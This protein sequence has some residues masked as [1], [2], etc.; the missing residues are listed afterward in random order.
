MEARDLY[1]IA[2]LIIGSSAIAANLT[3]IVTFCRFKRRILR[4]KVNKFLLSLAFADLL[5]GVFSVSLASCLLSN[6]HG[7]VYKVAGNIPLFGSFFASIL[8]LSLLSFDR[9][10]A[11][12]MPLRYC[13]IVTCRR[14]AVALASNWGFTFLM[15]VQQ[16]SFYF[17]FSYRV[18][19]RARGTIMIICFFVGATILTLTNVLLYK[20]TK[21]QYL[22]TTESEGFFHIEKSCGEDTG[23]GDT[24]KRRR[25]KMSDLAA[26]RECLC[27]VLVFICCYLPLSFYRLIYTYG[28]TFND[29]HGRRI[30]LLIALLSSVI[31]PWIYFF[32]RKHFRAL[33]SKRPAKPDEETFNL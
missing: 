16:Y 24:P 3:V 31:N 9:L 1:W 4:R 26:T 12:E 11:V 6:Q 25:P 28:F 13:S 19:L 22:K 29:L 15:C 21:E 10:I 18:E 8:S 14:I 5:V 20:A 27:I 17:G 32:K 23:R 7:M 2:A 33:L 30:C